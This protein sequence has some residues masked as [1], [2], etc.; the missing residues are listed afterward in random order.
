MKHKSW[1]LTAF[2]AVALT[3][4]AI[5]L[6]GC[7]SACCFTSAKTQPASTE[8]RAVQYTCPMH[9]DVV[10]ATPGKCPKCG[11]DLMEKN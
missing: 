8:P 2:T 11:M 1:K 3:V 9:P 4:A 5:G 10:T 6:V 7:K